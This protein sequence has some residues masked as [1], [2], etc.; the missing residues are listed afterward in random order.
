MVILKIHT[1]F[2]EVSAGEELRKISTNLGPRDRSVFLGS[3]AA[4]RMVDGSQE[5][6]LYAM[7]NY[8][9][10]FKLWSLREV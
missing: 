8:W 1:N 3:L 5:V 2:P 9:I 10:T 7:D 6:G 4:A